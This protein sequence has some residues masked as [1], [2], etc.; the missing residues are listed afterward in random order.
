MIQSRAVWMFTA[1]IGIG[2]IASHASAQVVV[3]PD[4]FNDNNNALFDP[5]ISVVTTGVNL[6]VQA[7]VSA[8]RRYVH[9]NMRPQFST[10]TGFT[11]FQFSG[12]TQPAANAGA[13]GTGVGQPGG[14]LARPG[15]NR[16]GD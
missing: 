11:T 9:L 12:T 7:T 8:D 15:M 2:L 4:F 1:A 6:D 5:Q 10:L 13:G 14:V 16:V 3:D